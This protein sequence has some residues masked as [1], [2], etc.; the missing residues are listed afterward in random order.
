MS[1]TS[2]N[3]KI[4]PQVPLVAVLGKLFEKRRIDGVLGLGS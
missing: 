3:T 4:L 2:T 1:E